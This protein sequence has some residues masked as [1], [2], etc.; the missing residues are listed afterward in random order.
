[1]ALMRTWADSWLHGPKIA[2]NALKIARNH[3]Y[4]KS[5][6]LELAFYIVGI[7]TSNSRISNTSLDGTGQVNLPLVSE[8]L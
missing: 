5:S 7:S 8:V 2:G 1:M 4:W 6:S 3:Q